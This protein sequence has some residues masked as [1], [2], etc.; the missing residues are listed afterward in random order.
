MG[1]GE[2]DRARVGRQSRIGGCLVKIGGGML[3]AGRRMAEKPTFAQAKSLF[4]R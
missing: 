1:D 4:A 2:G 3:L